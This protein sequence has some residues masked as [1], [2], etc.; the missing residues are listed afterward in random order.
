MPFRE[1]FVDGKVA[2]IKPRYTVYSHVLANWR[3]LGGSFTFCRCGNGRSLGDGAPWW[4]LSDVVVSGH[5]S[6][7]TVLTARRVFGSAS[8]VS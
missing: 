4:K 8:T 7:E 5:H 6:T 1:C 3:N 2:I